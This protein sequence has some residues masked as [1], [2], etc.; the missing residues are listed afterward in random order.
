MKLI[1]Q[2]TVDPVRGIASSDPVLGREAELRQLIGILCRRYKNNPALLGEPGVG[3]TAIAKELARRLALGR[4]PPQ[5]SGKRLLQLEL[6][7]LIAGTK[8]RGEF[9]ERV[10]DLL[11]EL[12]RAGG[13]I[14]FVDEMHTLMGAGSAEGAIDAANLIKPALS[15]GELQLLGATTFAEYSRLIEPDAALCRRFSV[16]RVPEPDRETAGEILRGL[17]PSLEAHHRVRISDEAIRAAVDYSVRYVSDRF[18]PDKALDL[19]DE[20]AAQSAVQKGKIPVSARTVAETLSARTGIP[21]HAITEGERERL[22][23]LEARLSG[24]VIAQTEAVRTAA[25]AV[26]R[27]RLGLT[28]ANRPVASLLFAGP[29]GVGKTKLCKALALELFGSEKAMIRLDMTEYAE[30][31]SASKLLGAPPGYVGHGK[32]GILTDAVRRRPCSLLLFDELEKAHPSVLGLLLQLMEDGILTDSLHRTADFRSCIVV[33]TTNAGAELSGRCPTGFSPL[34]QR[35][36]TLQ[37]L[38]AVFSPEFLGRIDAV[39]PFSALDVDA[40]T[41]IAAMMLQKTAQRALSAGVQLRMDPQSARV[42]AAQCES[43]PAGARQLRRCIQQQVET[44]LAE[45][46]LRADRLPLQ[47]GLLAEGGRLLL[48]PS[49]IRAAL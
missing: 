28:E 39:V 16:V 33:M 7:S 47:A 44:P 26:R 9:E 2:F 6:P 12:R 24:Q 43:H 29:T 13:I 32:A 36:L 20:S 30:M 45:L 22:R 27:G 17:R 38:S 31:H 14:L 42:L 37:K 8:Y 1:E 15:S 11:W 23:G 41:R 48:R 3:K 25:A 49:A 46:L 19:L 35:D 34:T 5:L 40:L 18:L 10:R 4:V 21:V